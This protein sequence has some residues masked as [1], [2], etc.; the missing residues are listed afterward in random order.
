MKQS[1]SSEKNSVKIILSMHFFKIIFSHIS[2]VCGLLWLQFCCSDFIAQIEKSEVCLL[3]CLPKTGMCSFKALA[4]W[5]VRALHV[6]S[7]HVP[8]SHLSCCCYHQQKHAHT[9][10]PFLSHSHPNESTFASILVLILILGNTEMRNITFFPNLWSVRSGK[11][12][13]MYTATFKCKQTGGKSGRCA[14]LSKPFL[15]VYCSVLQ[16]RS[17]GWMCCMYQPAA[18]SVFISVFHTKTRKDS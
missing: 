8:L 10:I 13:S 15:N 7:P 4:I 17:R 3:W 2:S 5:S 9:Y 14:D 16:E 1:P 12:L 6:L 18:C 11:Y